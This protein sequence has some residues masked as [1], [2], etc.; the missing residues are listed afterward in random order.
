MA[1]DDSF[2]GPWL[3]GTT[4]VAAYSG[5]YLVCIQSLIHPWL[6]IYIGQSVNIEDRVARHERRHDWR[7]VAA[8]RSLY[9]F[10]MEIESEERRRQVEREMIRRSNPPCNIQFSLF[11]N[12]DEQSSQLRAQ[13]LA[14]A[15]RSWM[16]FTELAAP[17]INTQTLGLQQALE[18]MQISGMNSMEWFASPSNSQSLG[19]TQ[20][21]IAARASGPKLF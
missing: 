18:E 15:Q 7:H 21:L 2:Q 1:Y 19:L 8:S 16:S 3:V 13:T 9:F 5:V 12:A 14:A 20:A 10:A 6:P 17:S 4:G 11:A